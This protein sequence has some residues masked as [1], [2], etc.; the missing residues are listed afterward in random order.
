[1]FYE[2]PQSALG[3][4]L[5]GLA[6][7]CLGVYDDVKGSGAGKKFAVQFGVAA[8]MYYLGFRVERLANPF[9]AD[10][11]LGLFA[12]PFTLFW[13]V[14]VVNAMNLIDGLDGLA[15]GVALFAVAT[16]FIVAFNQP[17]PL[18]MLFMAALAGA[19][20]GFL[21]YNFN[22]ATIFMGDTGSMF[23]GFILAASAIR[24][25]QKSTTAVA[26]LMPI[27][28]LGLP[29]LDTMLAMGG[30]PSGAGRSSGGQG[31]H[32]SSADGARADASAGGLRAVRRRAWR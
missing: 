32:P 31:A 14:G 17:N 11:E 12:I 29:I 27:I 25:N 22:P 28:A 2:H 7:A 10:I 8:L 26:I 30:E 18:M 21:F 16:T 20:V 3:I 1:M 6:I 13:I 15:G 4:F 5:G 9:G 19:I 24:T 23:L